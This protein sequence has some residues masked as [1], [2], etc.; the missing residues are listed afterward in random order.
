MAPDSAR[1][2][3]VLTQELF[4]KLE[5]SDNG[6][7]N[8][9]AEKK[10]QKY[11]LNT[12]TKKKKTE[13]LRIL[14]N[15]FKNPIILILVSASVL[16]L[17][18]GNSIDALMILI[19]VII[20]AALGFW[21]E[22]TASDEIKKLLSIIQVRVTV[23][24]DGSHTTIPIEY[25]VPGDIVFL[26]A[27]DIVPGD[28]VILDSK[29]LFVNESILTG[30][31]YP[32]EKAPLLVKAEKQNHVFM[33]S[34]VISGTARVL[35][36]GTS[37]NTEIGKI[38][39]RLRLRP[40]ETEFER[41]IRKF[42]YFLMEVTF[43][44]VIVI[45]GINTYFGRQVMESFLFSI[46]LAV[47]LTPQLLPTIITLNL[48]KG[49]KRMAK[50][51]VIVKRLESI[52]NLG[53]MNVLCSDKTGTLTLG[54]MLIKSA[55]DIMGNNNE[56]ILFYSFVNASF[57]SG[58][59]NP[60]DQAI[61]TQKKFDLKGIAK[62]DEIPYDFIRKRLSVLVSHQNKNLQITKGAVRNILEIC[63]LVESNGEIT[64]INQMKEKIQ[65]Q[66]ESLSVQGFRII[67]VSY[68]YVDG[69]QITKED[70]SKMVFL[71]FISFYDP[72]KPDIVEMIENLKNMGIETK[73]I[74]GDN[75]FVAKYVASQIGLNSELLLT[76]DDLNK[77]S[78]DALVNTVNHTNIFAEIEPIQKERIILAL[79]KS[80]NVVGYLGDGVNDA[81]A[82]HA[83]DVGISVESAVDVA[84]NSADM[85]LLE[86]DLGILAEGVSLGRNT[87]ANTLKYVFMATSANFGNM[88]SM[89]GA[90]LFL[91]FLPLLPKQI[92][93]EN[94][95]TDLPELTISTD[96]VD[97]KLVQR[98]RRWNISL[99]RKF[100]ITFGFLSVVFDFLTFLA[101]RISN[102]TEQV[103]RTGWFVE[104]V[105]SASIMVLIIRT[106]QPFYN[107]RPSKYLLIATLS[108]VV[109]TLIF[110]LTPIASLFGFSPMPIT[111][112][113]LIGVIVTMYV[114]S[115]ELIKRKFYSSIKL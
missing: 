44:L 21:Q 5:T 102:S 33:S 34:H 91:S 82:L 28:G 114:A 87:F 40:P 78:N 98:P 45:F 111:L 38:S 83:A 89:A 14:F 39:E 71:G 54:E 81:I 70:E 23:I 1:V 65:S 113:L 41:G 35:I 75:K 80:N 115:A 19:I 36:T 110:P 3:N 100:M 109:F 106:Q 68:K 26:S 37:R 8:S 84:K 112:Y 42:G 103:F 66:F 88:F 59:V 99:V 63:T 4:S 108:L 64:P 22:K 31:T 51:K 25:V 86:K 46:A 55:T 17:Y 104:S 16:S 76:G 52:E 43:A 58:F 53:S 13:T 61:R 6:I 49:A 27:G 69:S 12:F 24:R 90:S 93:I 62:L 2:G 101:L 94:L 77:F 95:M 50:S 30:E 73:I 10:L 7:S 9:I 32:V 105:I 56:K 47:G 74:T 85:I 48:S 15:Q 57:E 20:S 18:I 11:G 97:Q 107:S 60:I 96:N 72:L 67:G 92:L 29:D 79:K